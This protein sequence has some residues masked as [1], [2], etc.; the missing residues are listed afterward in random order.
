[1][2]FFEKKNKLC[3]SKLTNLNFRKNKKKSQSNIKKFFSS[4]IFSFIF[5][6]R[7]IKLRYIHCIFLHLRSIAMSSF[8]YLFIFGTILFISISLTNAGKFNQSKFS[9]LLLLNGNL[10]SIWIF[11]VRMIQNAVE[12]VH[13]VPVVNVNVKHLGIHHVIEHNAVSIL[14]HDKNFL[15]YS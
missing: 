6:Y 13:F 9:F 3:F 4:F 7:S 8:N 1:M 2:I 11:P 15:I 14:N 10:Q 5:K 12:S